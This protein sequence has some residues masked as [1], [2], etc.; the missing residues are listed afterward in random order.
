[1]ALRLLH[2]K[3]R[4]R[5]AVVVVRRRAELH[6]SGGPATGDQ[7][8][9]NISEKFKMSATTATSVKRSPKRAE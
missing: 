6:G 7:M 4:L 3:H 9:K 5:A 8:S 1:M 2:R